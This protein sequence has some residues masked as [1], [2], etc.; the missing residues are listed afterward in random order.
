MRGAA[1]TLATA[2]FV[3]AAGIFGFFDWIFFVIPKPVIFPILVF[4][5]LEITAQSFHATPV[6]HYPA[7]AMACIPALAYLAS[8]ALGQLLPVMGKPFAELPPHTQQ[9][10]QTVMVLAGGGTFIVT[11]VL[12]ATALAHLID[13]RVRAA[14]RD[15]VAVR[16]F[17]L[18]WHHSLAAGLVPDRDARRG[19]RPAPERRSIRGD[20][21]A[22]ALSLVGRLC[23]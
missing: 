23:S 13:G 2:L 8:L 20:R 16:R 14:R 9:W 12:W 11:S 22:N 3:G 10:V 4:V 21:P 6:R 5:G 7:V 19:D 1:Y 18:V 15:P 17:F